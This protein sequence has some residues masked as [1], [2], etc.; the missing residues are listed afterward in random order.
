MINLQKY[1]SI[2]LTSLLKSKNNRRERCFN[3]FG[4]VDDLLEKLLRN[5]LN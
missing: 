4:K 3:Q 2:K 5:Q 1:F